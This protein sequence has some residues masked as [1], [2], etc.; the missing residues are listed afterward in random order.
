[1]EQEK[2]PTYTERTITAKQ[3]RDE[4]PEQYTIVRIIEIA[5]RMREKHYLP[6]PQENK[7]LKM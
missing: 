4:Y 7:S 2:E 1:M 5:Q 3:M 6:E